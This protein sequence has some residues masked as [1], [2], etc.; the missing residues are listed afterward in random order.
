MR[1]SVLLSVV[2]KIALRFSLSC[3]S[4]HR[5]RDELEKEGFPLTTL[6]QSLAPDRAEPTDLKPSAAFV[7]DHRS[8]GPILRPFAESL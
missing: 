4:V 6:W 3:S 8:D 1:T 2:K 7:R 5:P